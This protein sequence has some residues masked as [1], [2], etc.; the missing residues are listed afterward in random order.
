MENKKQDETL[1]DLV[2]FGLMEKSLKDRTKYTIK[3]LANWIDFGYGNNLRTALKNASISD[4]YTIPI[5]EALNIDFCEFCT[6]K[7][8]DKKL[9]K[10]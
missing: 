9:W 7:L 4:K 2:N 1:L 6:R 8:K 10:R 5:V 3:D